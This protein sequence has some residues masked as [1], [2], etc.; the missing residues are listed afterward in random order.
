MQNYAG[1]LDHSKACGAYLV[2]YDQSKSFRQAHDELAMTQIWHLFYSPF[3][4]SDTNPTLLKGQDLYFV[5][6]SIDH[7]KFWHPTNAFPSSFI[8]IS[9]NKVYRLNKLSVKFVM[10]QSPFF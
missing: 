2:R 10:G 5:G 9:L 1:Q 8:I 3:N 7:L 4:W 6:P